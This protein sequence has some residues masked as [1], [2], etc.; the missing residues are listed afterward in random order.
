MV[1]YMNKN[2]TAIIKKAL[3]ASSSLKDEE[4]KKFMQATKDLDTEQ[5]LEILIDITPNIE[6]IELKRILKS[7]PIEHQYF[8][9][10]LV[11][12]MDDNDYAEIIDEELEEIKN[13]LITN[14][15]LLYIQDTSI[16]KSIYKTNL[17]KYND[18]ELNYLLTEVKLDSQNE[19]SALTKRTIKAFLDEEKKIK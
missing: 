4:L 16:D 7:V 10:L 3:S 5:L 8:L 1:K 18:E 15:K 11:S 13:E 12:L 17:R 2:I 19:F 9:E 14:A 6:K